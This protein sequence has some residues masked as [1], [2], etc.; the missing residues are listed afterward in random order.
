MIL[1]KIFIKYW[2]YAVAHAKSGIYSYIKM[3][4]LEREKKSGQV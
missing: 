1:A 2:L 4:Q 3:M